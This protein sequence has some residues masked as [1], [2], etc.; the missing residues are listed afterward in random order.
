MTAKGNGRL[1]NSAIGDIW[2]HGLAAF[3]LTATV[4]IGVWQLV[5]GAAILSPLLIS[6]LWATNALVPPILLLCYWAFGGPG[7]LMHLVCKCGTTL[8][9]KVKLLCVAAEV[10]LLTTEILTLV[11]PT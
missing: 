10:L 7:I 11:H 1:A 9:P 2:L 8:A 3:L 4:A 6:V 5:A